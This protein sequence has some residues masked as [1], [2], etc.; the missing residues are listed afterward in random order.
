[1]KRVL[2]ASYMK[3]EAVRDYSPGWEYQ[4]IANNE[5]NAVLQDVLNL[6]TIEKEDDVI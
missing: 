5:Y 2:E 4:Q 3:K 6:I 1:L